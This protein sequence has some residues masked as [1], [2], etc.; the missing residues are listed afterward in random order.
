MEV[1][2]A[3]KTAKTIILSFIFFWREEVITN[4]FCTGELQDPGTAFRQQGE[5]EQVLISGNFSR[6]VLV[7]EGGLWS[8][9]EQGVIDLCQQQH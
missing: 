2:K 1:E 3:G 7:L 5:G 4:L 6:I 8:T 9:G